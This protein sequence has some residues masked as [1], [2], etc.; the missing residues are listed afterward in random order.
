MVLPVEFD[1]QPPGVACHLAA[2]IGFGLLKF[3]A[4]IDKRQ[5]WND[6]QTQADSPC[7]TEMSLSARNGN[8]H[9]CQRRENETCVN[10][11]VREE[12]EPSIAMTLLELASRLGTC[13]RSRRTTKVS[14]HVRLGQSEEAASIKR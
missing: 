9:G 1:N 10:H 6:R 13:D 8:D 11:E 14:V 4:K 12:D 5:G 7:R 2:R 3:D